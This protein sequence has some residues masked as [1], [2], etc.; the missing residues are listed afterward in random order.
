MYVNAHLIHVEAEAEREKDHLLEALKLLEEA[1]VGYQKEADYEGLGQA[2]Q[3][4][5]L[6]Y[7]HLFL[8]S[9]NKV[10]AILAKKDAEA[11]L[12]INQKYNITSKLGSCYFRL[13]DVEIL[14]ENYE[15]AAENYQK[16]L[17]NYSGTKSE[18]GDYEYHLGTALGKLGK[19]EEAEK[20]MLQGL[21]EIQKN[22]GE[23]DIFLTHVWESGCLMRLAELLTE[24]NRE[25]AKEYLRQ[26]QEII[27]ND[28]KLVIR[29]RQ[30]AEFKKTLVK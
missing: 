12:E 11:S 26:A 9:K 29:K 22:S 24:K 8:V 3:S 21:S 23:V 18:K 1:I 7:K 20:M 27:E 2:L 28:P 6:T 19:T 10:F 4:R 16:A 5:E 25:R 14:F 30:L 17:D 15:Q 13:G